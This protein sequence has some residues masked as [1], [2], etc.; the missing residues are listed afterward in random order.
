MGSLGQAAGHLGPICRRA[1]KTALKNIEEMAL[2][3]WN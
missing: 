1:T 3:H 2:E